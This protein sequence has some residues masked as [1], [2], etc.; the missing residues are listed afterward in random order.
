MRQDVQV[1]GIIVMPNHVHGILVLAG[2]M[3][4]ARRAHT[5]AHPAGVE[6]PA[7]VERFGVPV[8]GSVPTI[9]RAIKSAVTKRI[10]KARQTPGARVWQRGYY[11]RAIRDEDSL[12]RI[13]E[14]IARNFL[15]WGARMNEGL[16]IRSRT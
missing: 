5:R 15:R 11:E 9:I 1:D 14:Y 2:S 7:A 12:A 13:R 3:G 4:T 16:V 10:N 8:P 6:Q